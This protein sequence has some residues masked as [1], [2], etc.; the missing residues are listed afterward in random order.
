MIPNI[1]A[2]ETISYTQ[3][4]SG[5]DPATDTLIFD[6]V[7][8]LAKESITATDNG[9]GSFLIEVAYDVTDAWKPD[10]YNYQAHI[11]TAAGARNYVEQGSFEVKPRFAD[12][13][14]GYDNRS[15]VK[16]TLDALEATLEGKASQDQQSY[17]IAGRSLSRL[18]PSELI[19]WRE[20]YKAEYARELSAARIA[21]GL[22]NP[23]KIRVRM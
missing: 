2:G 20:K 18:S 11:T 9:N 15:H 21:A 6:C 8:D 23:N 17:S 3:T 22:G 1:T 10:I 13:S 7:T 4:F 14:S 5:Y 12:M 19:N 16:K